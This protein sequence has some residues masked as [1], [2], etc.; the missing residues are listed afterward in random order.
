[1][2]SELGHDTISGPVRAARLTSLVVALRERG[3]D[4]QHDLRL[5]P[6]VIRIGK[7][8]MCDVVV[9]DPYASGTHCVLE[10]DALGTLMIK[11]RGSKNGTWVDGSPVKEV[12]VQ[13]G[14][15]I[16]VGRTHLIALGERRPDSALVQLR[17]QDRRFRAEIDRAL[18]AARG[19][20]SILIVGETGTGKE[21]MARAI[22]EASRRNPGPFV[23]VNC[24]GFPRELISTELFGHVRGAFTGA[25]V[26]RDGVF[27][28][29]DGGTLFLDELG[30]LPLD[31]QPHLLRVLETRRV[32][33]VGG[34]EREIDVRFVAATNR[35]D[36]LG[37]PASPIREDLFHRVAAVVVQLPPLRRRKDDIPELIRVFLEDLEPRH[38]RR[39]LR[40]AALDALIAHDWPGNVRE[41]RQAITRAVSL[42][43]DEIDVHDLG[44]DD[45]AA[46]TALASARPAAPMRTLRACDVEAEDEAMSRLDLVQRE[47]MLRA[48]E[49]KG[50]MRAAAK[51]LGMAKSTF[52]DKAARFG[53]KAPAR[54][55]R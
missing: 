36:G 12:E 45:V 21:L 20:A 38:G 22:H 42:T 2:K 9:D 24:G 51:D 7:S 1:M 25:E 53:L 6:G 41:L 49:A 26:A 23:P 4:R 46:W 44:L 31:L 54:K 48:Y 19:D 18:R 35:L 40:G 3:S 28:N 16:L 8:A 47:M 33:R 43:D 39:R 14:A 50:S 34:D 17:G 29:A 13:P 32:R 15:V 52:A 27:V 11:D 55:P 5:A 30:E 10:R 37:T